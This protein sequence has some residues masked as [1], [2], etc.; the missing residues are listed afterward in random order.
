MSV[1]EQVPYTE[2]RA[3]GSSNIF[4]ITFHL[5]D[6]KDLVVMVNK[7][8]PPVGAYSIQGDT[9]V[10]GTPPKEGDLVELTRDTQMDR[11]TNFKSYDNSFRPETINFDLDKIWLVLQEANLVDA[12][13][14]AR[15]KQEIEWRRTHDFNYDELAQVRDAQVFGALKQYLD[16]ILAATTPNIFGGVTAG[17][18]FALDKKSVQTHL[19]DI[20][21]K[22]ETNRLY[23]DEQLSL[24]ANALDVYPKTE[25][26]NKAETYNKDEIDN[27]FSSFAGGRKAYK[28]L[29][30]AN[31]DQA[32]WPINGVIEITNDSVIEN[33]GIYQWD[34]T[35]LTKS[36]YDPLTQ[37]KSYTNTKLNPISETLTFMEKIELT[38]VAGKYVSAAGVV[39]ETPG[40]SYAV[41]NVANKSE[42][43]I[44]TK[45]TN[46]LVPALVFVDSSNVVISTLAGNQT[47]TDYIVAVPSNANTVFINIRND[48]TVVGSLSIAELYPNLAEDFIEANDLVNS[49]SAPLTA[50]T[51][52]LST[53]VDQ[54]L[55]AYSGKYVN[56]TGAVLDDASRNYYTLAVTEGQ[57]IYVSTYSTGTPLPVLFKNSSGTV[58]GNFG[59]VGV[60]YINQKVTVPTT[61]VLMILNFRTLAPTLLKAN[62]A[63]FEIYQDLATTVK[64]IE[65][66]VG[67]NGFLGKKWSSF[68][69]S[70]TAQNRWQPTLSQYLQ[71][72]THTNCGI[73]GTT[74]SSGGDY[75]TQPMHTDARINALPTDSKIVF[76]MGGTNDWGQSCPIGELSPVG[77]TAFNNLTFIGAL[78]EVAHKLLT[79]FN[80]GQLIVWMTPVWGKNVGR[81]NSGTWASPY[82]NKLNLNISD[83]QEAVRLVA[84]KYGFPLIDLPTRLGWNEVNAAL[85]YDNETGNYIHPNTVGGQRMAAVISKDISLFSNVADLV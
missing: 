22:F 37:A 61:A 75:P 67:S 56:N 36:A 11:E 7:E 3:T 17:V 57:E 66:M 47:Y 62:A 43:K 32:N 33:N 55:T 51:N 2:Y 45:T 23:V 30:A 14:L 8:I 64:S 82:Y 74:V 34:G 44:T 48:G 9:V 78:E 13:I 69:D 68:G 10:F 83:Y 76:F 46:T 5:P 53:F 85:F 41:V 77:T 25:N 58:V 16:T 20:A 80:T 18:V 63:K 15:L 49:M 60:E 27:A 70:I 12:K 72:G 19:E 73:G 54:E 84:N 42:I 24:K 71:L 31:A 6:P 65:N 29:A 59:V 28:T 1:P 40:N 26:Y 4:E 35:N 39:S 21:N 52:A 81:V 79:R 38:W 50:N